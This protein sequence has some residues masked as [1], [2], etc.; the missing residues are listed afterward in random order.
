MAKDN[1]LVKITMYCI[2]I[3]IKNKILNLFRKLDKK[4]IMTINHYMAIKEDKIS[5]N[6]QCFNVII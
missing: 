6:I 5:H 3:Y 1:I 2:I 4:L